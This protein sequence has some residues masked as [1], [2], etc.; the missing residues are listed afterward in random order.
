MK[1][2]EDLKFE[3]L[4]YST[5]GGASSRMIFDNGFG[6]SVVSHS[7]SYGGDSGLFE[8]AVLDSNGNLTYETPV[9]ND[10]IGW[11]SEKGVSEIMEKIQKL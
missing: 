6:I 7:M 10:V 3:K 8:A 4:N 11:L 2:F 1:K 9:T 5:L